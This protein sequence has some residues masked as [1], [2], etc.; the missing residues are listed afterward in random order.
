MNSIVYFI[1]MYY[2]SLTGSAPFPND[3]TEKKGIWEYTIYAR[4]AQ[5]TETTISYS[6]SPL[7]SF[8]VKEVD[9]ITSVS[10]RGDMN[11]DTLVINYISR[12]YK[13]LNKSMTSP[14][15]STSISEERTYEI[16]V[17]RN[18]GSGTFEVSIN[19]TPD[20]DGGNGMFKT[21]AVYLLDTLD[22]ITVTGPSSCRY[23]T[24][25]GVISASNSEIISSGAMGHM[26]GTVT[27]YEY[28]LTA[29]N[30]KAFF[31]NQVE[32]LSIGIRN[33]SFYKGKNTVSQDWTAGYDL[34]GRKIVGTKNQCTGLV[35]T[36]GNKL[37]FMG[38]VPLKNTN[39][40]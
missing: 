12:F 25:V 30:Q 37:V 18:M 28:Q 31:L 15:F 2:L 39:M 35:V 6:E 19:D 34:L 16:K 5:F 21:M 11:G 7:D 33:A 8:M 23:L 29:F 32:F 10:W 20:Y 36:K 27:R 9:T 26:F 17:T 38:K 4:T 24:R 14:L 40:P 13:S 1:C 3:V 22:L